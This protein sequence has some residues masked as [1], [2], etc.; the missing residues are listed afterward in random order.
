MDFSS[1]TF[2]FCLVLANG[3]F[4]MLHFLDTFSLLLFSV[5]CYNLAFLL[6]ILLELLLLQ[7]AKFPI[8]G[9]NKV[10]LFPLFSILFYCIFPENL[11]ETFEKDKNKISCLEVLLFSPWNSYRTL[12][13]E[14]LN[15]K[16]YKYLKKGEWK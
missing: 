14:A 6:C 4:S 7:Q 11:I 2:H 1:C 16:L 5:I 9:I 8:S 13:S 10:L 3:T 12:L 15:A